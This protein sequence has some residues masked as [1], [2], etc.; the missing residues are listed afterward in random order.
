MSLKKIFK[1]KKSSLGKRKQKFNPLYKFE[2][3][4]IIV[5]NKNDENPFFGSE[6]SDTL[7]FEGEEK[8]KNYAFLFLGEGCEFYSFLVKRINF[9]CMTWKDC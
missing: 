9:G 2:F 8:L 5:D 6:L 3:Q 7:F 4:R 1:R